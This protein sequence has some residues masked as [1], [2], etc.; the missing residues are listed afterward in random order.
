MA[1]WAHSRKNTKHEEKNKTK[2]KGATNK[3]TMVAKYFKNF[4]ISKRTYLTKYQNR[5]GIKYMEKV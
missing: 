1:Y 3:S 4:F 5:R 2:Y